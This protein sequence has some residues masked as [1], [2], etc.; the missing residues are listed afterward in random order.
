MAA[1][2]T[3]ARA[4]RK[5]GE[6][7]N[8]VLVMGAL[9]LVLLLAALDQTIVS[10][11]L[12]KIASEFNGLSELSW[13]VTAYLLASAVTTPLYGKISDLFGRKK[14]LSVAVIIFLIGSML[15]G[16][17]QSMTELII[18]RGVQGLGA[19]GLITLVL[20]G[21]G[22]VVPLRERGR[23]QG[24]FG[25]VFGVS[26][27]IGPLLGGVFTDHF[28]WRWIFYINI[29]LGLLALAAITLYLH[30]PLHRTEHRIDYL[31]ALLLS[32]STVSLLLVSVWGGSRYA[33]GSAETIGLATLGVLLAA[34]FVWWESHA[35]EPIMPPAL[36][37]N[38]IFRTSSL[39]ALVSGL[40]MF[41]ALIFLPEYQQLVRG[42]SA[43]KSGL[44]MLPLVFG[45]LTASI[46]SGRIISRTGSY[47][48]FPIFGTLTTGI[49]LFLLSHVAMDTPQW[50]LSIWM[51]VTGVGIGS[52]MQVMTL[53]VQ[54]ATDRRDLGTATSLVTFFRS[55]GSSFGVAIFGAVLSSRF[56]VHIAALVPG[57]GGAASGGSGLTGGI[58]QIHA[59][60]PDMQSRVLEA[61]V[62]SFQELFLWVIP[63]VALAFI[64]ALF[65]KDKPLT[66]S[67]RQMAEGEAFEL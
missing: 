63:C 62:L 10:T 7:K 53:A 46:F 20:A 40:A 58:A 67:S 30:V 17:A 2:N 43:T 23:Y 55:M 18:F 31:G 39:L 9:M 51:V 36:F 34:L 60:P 54:N 45:L 32:V 11:A 19:G 12:P 4:V 24:L 15:A 61:F 6:Q 13:V 65:L 3:P 33:W 59:L 50:L 29:P 22:D 64:I 26:S 56:A 1:H 66:E 14:V 25:A 5:E 42:Y 57:A 27:V 49:G 41:A 48:W 8:I 35:K 21:I 52:F 37:K 47:R 44:L 28:S 16:M 38:S